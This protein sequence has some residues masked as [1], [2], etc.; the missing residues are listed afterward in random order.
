MRGHGFPTKRVI[1]PKS[2]VLTASL[3]FGRLPAKANV[4]CRGF[5]V[6]TMSLSKSSQLRK[7]PKPVRATLC[8]GKDATYCRK[9][10]NPV[11]LSKPQI[12]ENTTLLI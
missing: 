1:I 3:L 4:K 2:C 6:A 12:P 7:Q 8:G 5:H 9:E 11:R 10:M